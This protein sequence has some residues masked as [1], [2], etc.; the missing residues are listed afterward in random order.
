M[1]RRISA[2][3]AARNVFAVRMATT[4]YFTKTHEWVAIDD[5]TKIATVGIT[6]VAAKALGD[7]VFVG[8]FALPGEEVERD[9]N[10]AELEST[11][12]AEKVHSPVS[13]VIVEVNDKVEANPKVVN[14]DAEGAAWMAKI[15][16]SKHAVDPATLL[17]KAQYDEFC[18]TEAH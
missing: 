6:K 2:A 14:E 7:L 11:K 5:S 17:T 15:D 1:F 12:V 4:T 10:V 3:T 9:A 13:G 8:N 18:A 16:V